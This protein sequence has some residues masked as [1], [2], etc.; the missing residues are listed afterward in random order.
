MVDLSGHGKKGP[1]IFRH[2]VHLQG[3]PSE[4]QTRGAA[5]GPSDG[6]HQKQAPLR[7]RLCTPQLGSSKWGGSL[8]LI[9]L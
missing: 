4:K 8:I 7:G 6:S 1:H 9:R 5:G 3:T 2:M